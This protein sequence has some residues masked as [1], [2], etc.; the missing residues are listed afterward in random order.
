MRNARKEKSDMKYYKELYHYNPNHDPRNG[1]F[2]VGKSGYSG[3]GTIKT[4]KAGGNVYRISKAAESFGG[5]N[6]YGSPT[7]DENDK[8]A[9]ELNLKRYS[10]KYTVLSDIK[11]ADETQLGKIYTKAF[12]NNKETRKLVRN[13]LL[14]DEFEHR[15]GY[16]I[17]DDGLKLSDKANKYFEAHPDEKSYYEPLKNGRFREW[18]LDCP[19]TDARAASSIYAKQPNSKA[20][21]ILTESLRKSGYTALSDIRGYDVSDNPIIFL[22]KEQLKLSESKRIVWKYDSNKDK[23]GDLG[24]GK[25]FNTRS[26]KDRDRLIEEKKYYRDYKQY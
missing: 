8:W 19:I 22:N 26:R 12:L 21:K 6:V 3:K 10:Q 17:N 23:Y 24:F 9:K 7:S 5:V 1:R 14:S 20:A 4:I 25:Y 11:I 16:A 18:Y 15:P 13:A 2:T